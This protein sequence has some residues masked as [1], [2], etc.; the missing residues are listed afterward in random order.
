M[1]LSVRNLPPDSLT[2]PH[3]HLSKSRRLHVFQV[4][5][6][7]I[8]RPV[9]GYHLHHAATVPHDIP[10][11]PQGHQRRSEVRVRGPL[12]SIPKVVKRSSLTVIASGNP[13]GRRGL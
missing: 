1:P 5:R 13:I 3:T 2:T 10:N 6:E 9:E 11:S 12:A 8:L 7:L 4:A